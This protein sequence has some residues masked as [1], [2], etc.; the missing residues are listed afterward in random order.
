MCIFLVPLQCCRRAFFSLGFTY[1]TCFIALSWPLF[2]HAIVAL[3]LLDVWPWFVL[4]K[5]LLWGFLASVFSLHVHIAHV[6]Y[7]YKPFRMPKFVFRDYSMHRVY[8]R[9]ISG[10]FSSTFQ[11]WNSINMFAYHFPCYC[12]AYAI[13]SVCVPVRTHFEALHFHPSASYVSVA[14]ALS[15]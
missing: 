14:E 11:C 4:V 3:T 6:W 10:L 2:L 12:I 9:L 7:S 13:A 1:T 15:C 5:C 8:F